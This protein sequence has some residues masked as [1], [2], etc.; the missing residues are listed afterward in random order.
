MAIALLKARWTRE[1]HLSWA[2][3]RSTTIV[4]RRWQ[5]HW[6]AMEGQPFSSTTLGIIRCIPTAK[7]HPDHC[8][9]EAFFRI[10]GVGSVK[11][12]ALLVN[13]QV[14]LRTERLRCRTSPPTPFWGSL[15]LSTGKPLLLWEAAAIRTTLS[16]WAVAAASMAGDRR[17]MAIFTKLWISAMREKRAIMARSKTSL[18]LILTIMKWMTAISDCWWLPVTDDTRPICPF[19]TMPRRWAIWVC[20]LLLTERLTWFIN[21]NQFWLVIRQKLLI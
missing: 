6:E 10:L 9:F 4:N 16:I 21:Q 7:A 8:K 15:R 1:M 19:T 20:V 11:M 18:G 12:V 13:T 17:I 3:W 14:P 2:F 5:Q